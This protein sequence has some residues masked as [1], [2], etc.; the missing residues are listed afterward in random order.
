M[1]LQ[2]N[3]FVKLDRIAKQWFIPEV[4][5]YQSSWYDSVCYG[6]E[7]NVKNT[8]LIVK[9]KRQRDFMPGWPIEVW[10]YEGPIQTRLV[11]TN[12]PDATL[13]HLESTLEWLKDLLDRT[14]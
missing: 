13:G 12:I 7:F 3:N 2:I 5:K 11:E 10:H 9:I 14:W 1:T 6:L 4:I 8:E